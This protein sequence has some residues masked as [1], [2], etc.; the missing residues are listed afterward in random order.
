MQKPTLGQ[1]IK[2]A[3]YLATALSQHTA[4]RPHQTCAVFHLTDNWAQQLNRKQTQPICDSCMTVHLLHNGLKLLQATCCPCC[5]LSRALITCQ[6]HKCTEYSL[7]V[8]TGILICPWQRCL[9]Y[10]LLAELAQECKAMPTGWP[11]W[12]PAC[13]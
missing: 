5:Q 8:A 1:Q 11:C 13:I 6:L 3:E 4:C 7:P 10:S 2:A 12:R 9:L